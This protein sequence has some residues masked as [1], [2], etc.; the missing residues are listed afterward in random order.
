MRS[1]V[2]ERESLVGEFLHGEAVA[3]GMVM[4]AD[5]STRFD[6]CTQVV[7]Q[8]IRCVIRSYSLPSTLPL[9]IC[10]EHGSKNLYE[11]TGYYWRICGSFLLTVLAKYP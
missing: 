9:N 10:G 4:V 2:I 6:Q 5:F 8:E 1:I 3:I 11:Q 7:A